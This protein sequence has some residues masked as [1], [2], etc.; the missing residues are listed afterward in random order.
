MGEE[1]EERQGD[2]QTMKQNSNLGTSSSSGH[3]GATWQSPKSLII[4]L[5]F[6]IV[7]L[8]VVSHL[9][10]SFPGVVAELLLE[11]YVDIVNASD[12]AILILVATWAL[13]GMAVSRVTFRI[14]SLRC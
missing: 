11:P 8:S 6:G 3:K 9:N 14:S 13:L 2:N 12:T 5:L 7:T 1:E 4:S 10:D